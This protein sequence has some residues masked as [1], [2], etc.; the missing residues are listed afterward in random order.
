AHR[1]RA[2]VLKEFAPYLCGRVLE[3][4]A[5]VGQF[6]AMLMGRPGIDELVAVEPNPDFCRVLRGT[7]PRVVVHAGTVQT[8]PPGPPW[9]AIVS[10]NVLEH[11]ANDEAEL[12][13]YASIL[14]TG[15]GR[16][17]L[18]VP[19]RQ[20]IYAPI[21]RDFGHYRRYARGELLEKLA[22][23]GFAI[24]S[25]HYFNGIGYL[26]W[27]LNFCVLRRRRFGVWAV[28][29]FDRLVLPAVHAVETRIMRPP[30]GQSLVAIACPK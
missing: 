12:N 6:T 24:D 20:E 19:A 9:D 14:A 23:A 5:G 21:D 4:G 29:W 18:F 15:R 16:L 8:L 11:I 30:V 2:A 7:C 26:L 13:T 10:I 25:L 22:R 1:Y 17:C 27:W 3:V 28:Q